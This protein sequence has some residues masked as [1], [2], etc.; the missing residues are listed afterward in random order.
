MMAT[1]DGGSVGFVTQFVLNTA[2]PKNERKTNAK[3]IA[4]QSLAVSG[5]S[6]TNWSVP[7]T[8]S[9]MSKRER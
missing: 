5:K 2:T 4:L 6:P 7:D 3:R 9:Q 8:L 1:P